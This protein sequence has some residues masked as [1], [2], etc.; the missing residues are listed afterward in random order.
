MRSSTGASPG[1]DSYKVTHSAVAKQR[2]VGYTKIV[3]E[4][5]QSVLS[6]TQTRLA[7]IEVRNADNGEQFMPA[8]RLWVDGNVNNLGSE[9]HENGAM[10]PAQPQSGNVV[11][12]EAEARKGNF[13]HVVTVSAGTNFNLQLKKN[14]DMS[15]KNWFDFSTGRAVAEPAG[16]SWCG[17]PTC[18]RTTASP[19]RRRLRRTGRRCPER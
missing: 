17:W 3:A 4:E 7:A 5:G 12:V 14:G 9:N 18:R 8:F 15:Y 16:R 11:D 1:S 6:G 13:D 19:I 10:Q 2:L